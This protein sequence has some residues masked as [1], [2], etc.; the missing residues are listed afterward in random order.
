MTTRTRASLR[1]GGTTALVSAAALLL[2]PTA[3]AAP[4]MSPSAAA[5]TAPL[6]PADLRRA[7]KNLHASGAGGALALVRDRR[8]TWRGTSGT[9]DIVKGG[10]VRADGYFRAG[11][12]TKLFT[13]TTVLQ[14][15]GEGRL[16]LDDP[17]GRHLPG[18]VPNGQA[19]TVRALLRHQSGLPDY[20]PT[21]FDAGVPG[22]IDAWV[23]TLRWTTFTPRELIART[24][25]LPHRPPG[26]FGYSNTNYIL[27]GMLIEKVTGHPYRDE[28]SRR[29]L[30][31]LGLRHTSLP[32]ATTGV[33]TPH[34]NGYL[35]VPGGSLVNITRL[36]PTTAGA[37]FEVIS[38]ASD[39]ARFDRALL[40][41]RL[42]RPEL[43]TAMKDTVPAVP[44]L[45]YGLGMVERQLRCG[46]VWGHDG[47]IA[48][49]S[50]RLYG[51][52]DGSRQAV[53]S[54]NPHPEPLNEQAGGAQ[55]AAA[56]DFLEAAFC[57]PGPVSR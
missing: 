23:R 50:T 15:V 31:P 48:G 27:A 41:G 44:G 20:L 47:F 2:A 13:A 7:L 11:S 45:R 46:S 35:Q 43:L 54:F 16:G 38:T 14:L 12:T 57:G 3:V 53:L 26:T 10:K 6:R 18:L 28:I 19:I 29:I 33:P 34:T 22:S 1:T 25:G 21:L 9:N 55:D 49:F 8:T 24:D 30:R 36:N 39:L 5:T 52:A 4:A 40:R 56:G 32:G 37:S 42:L 51:T 17:I